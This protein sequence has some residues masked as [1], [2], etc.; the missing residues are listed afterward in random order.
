MPLPDSFLDELVARCDIVDV[1]SRYVT[2]KK[3]GANYFGL[4]PFHSEKSPSFSVSREK[5]IYHCF[6]CGE[7]G[8][9]I[10]FVMKMENMNFLEAVRHLAGMAGMEVPEDD[11]ES[12]RRNH[13]ARLVALSTDAAR[14]YV[15]Q[16]YE[17]A[18]KPGLQYLLSRGLKPVTLKRFGL[19][20][21]PPGWDG[22]LKAMTAKGYT[23]GEL[24]ECGLAVQ[25]K[26]GGL[27]DRFRNRV[28]FPIIDVKGD[29]IAFGGRVMD[30]S[31]PKYLNSSDTP[32]FNKSRNLFAMN[33]AKKTKRNYFI[34]AEGYMDVIALHQAGFDCAVAS[35][36]T[37]LTEEQARLMVS[38]G[39]G[40]VVICYDSDQA[41][42][43]AAQRA[44]D[45]LNP[46]GLK[47]RVLRMS[48]AKDPDEYIRKNG[49]EAFED[50][51]S[52]SDTDVEYRL[53]EIR[54]GF[55]LEKN[56]DQVAYLRQAAQY[57]ATLRSAVEREVFS[58]RLAQET[59]VS[60]Q[61]ML[62]EV[63]RALKAARR[64]EK[65]SLNREQMNPVRQAQPKARQ[66]RYENIKSAKCE[67]GVLALA[68]SDREML[69]AASRQ[70]GPLEFSSPFLAKVYEMAL[71]RRSQGEEAGLA[72]CLAALEPEE[73]QLLAQI[74][75]HF[76][77]PEDPQKALRDYCETIQYEHLKKENDKETLLEIA[78]RKLQ[79]ERERGGK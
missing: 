38:R 74:V 27:Y 7:G 24:M 28:M 9:V 18:G 30:D 79:Q 2:L 16:L 50:L 44:I 73:G 41:G 37:S 34:L 31:T 56:E 62:D 43:K 67:E 12:G 65:A 42:R 3:Q 64:K 26:K 23:K 71:R 15:S 66:L 11:R 1:V 13:R 55:D 63:E 70:V 36:G 29:V 8:G 14:Y 60:Q 39:K 72:Q 57:L 4:C 6:G 17:P 5:Q 51:L 58:R 53:G 75:Q 69:D 52:R 76:Q 32:I 59:G 61:A 33:F 78:E 19:G 35:L 45:L 10:S 25:N 21:A 40:E 20:F 49:P 46:A 77:L 48:G 54:A 68:L 47:V 22:L